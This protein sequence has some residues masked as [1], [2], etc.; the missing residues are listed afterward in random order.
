MRFIALIL[1]LLFSWPA[2]AAVAIDV[3]GPGA[4]ACQNCTGGA[5]SPQSVTIT[6]TVHATT[7]PAMLCAIGFSGITPADI[8]SVVWQSTDSLAAISSA[9]NNG[10]GSF[11]QFWGGKITVG[12][13]N[14]TVVVS[15]TNAGRI[16]A[17]CITFS[18][19]DQ[20]TPFYHGTS[21]TSAALST[22]LSITPTTGA[23]DA[24]VGY[25]MDDSNLSSSITVGGTGGSSVV[26]STSTA[27]RANG[28]DY[29]LTGGSTLTGTFDAS[30]CTIVGV[31]A[32]V[33]AAA[34]GG[35]TLAPQRTM[36]GAGQ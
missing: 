1:A 13:T 29:N 30:C 22:S 27:G 10:T 14:G 4:A 21:A 25:F 9:V 35:A 28:S 32:A 36:T 8:T 33:K 12:A 18:G 26:I 23:G 24:I 34:G 19:V 6:G 20:A 2:C 11:I 5:A 3:N 7:N 31:A 16:N 15:F 17:N